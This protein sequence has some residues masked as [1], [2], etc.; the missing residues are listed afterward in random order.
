MKKEEKIEA[1]QNA[2]GLIEEAEQLVDDAVSDMNVQ[3]HYESYGKYGFNQ[4]LGNGNPYDS[5]LF[6]LLEELGGV[7]EQCGTFVEEEQASL[8][9]YCNKAYEKAEDEKCGI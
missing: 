3:S 7:C 5:S 1:I 6:T 2:I 9:N 4:L 8:C